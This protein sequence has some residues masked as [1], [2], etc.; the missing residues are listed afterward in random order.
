MG[1]TMIQHWQVLYLCAAL[2]VAAATIVVSDHLRAGE[3]PAAST[4]CAAALTAG[5]LW[6]VILVGL[7]QLG[8]VDRVVH[9]ARRHTPSHRAGTAPFAM[10]PAVSSE[11]ELVGAGSR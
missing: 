9:R 5:V 7:L 3:P 1:S 4:R 2:L 6:P 11:R 10:S 8:L